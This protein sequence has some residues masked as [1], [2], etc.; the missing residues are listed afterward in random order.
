MDDRTRE[1]ED[2]TLHSSAGFILYLPCV[3]Q[4][5][6]K[7]KG[8]RFFDVYLFSFLRMNISSQICFFFFFFHLAQIIVTSVHLLTASR[9]EVNIPVGCETRGAYLFAASY[10]PLNAHEQVTKVIK[11]LSTE[12]PRA[13]LEKFSSFRT[14]CRSCIPSIFQHIDSMLQIIAVR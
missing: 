7:A 14:R 8:L 5:E 6:A 9:R 12:G 2:N 10:P 3:I 4:I 1:G 13:N 11:T